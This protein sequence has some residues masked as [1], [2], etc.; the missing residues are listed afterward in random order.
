MMLPE[1][2]SENNRTLLVRPNY[3]SI[4]ILNI[5]HQLIT[6]FCHKQWHKNPTFHKLPFITKKANFDVDMVLELIHWIA[7][8]C[9][10]AIYIF[11]RVLVC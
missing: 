5:E 3:D 6:N 2:F 9:I 1:I 11:W 4:V 7:L 8:H 10:D